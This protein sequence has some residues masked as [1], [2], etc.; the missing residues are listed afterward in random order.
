MCRNAKSFAVTDGKPALV[1]KPGI[2]IADCAVGGSVQQLERR[3][4]SDIRSSED[5][6]G[7]EEHDLSHATSSGTT[8]AGQAYNQHWLIERHGY[9]TPAEARDHLRA[10][11][12]GAA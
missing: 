5:Q 7:A 9:C 3:E 10:K 2:A 1:D 11:A 6:G 12:G 8:N 4:D